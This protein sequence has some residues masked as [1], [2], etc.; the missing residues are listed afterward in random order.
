MMG[1]PRATMLQ[2]SLGFLHGFLKGGALATAHEAG[3]RE[4]RPTEGEL[5][6][7][8]RDHPLIM[9]SFEAGQL[10]RLLLGPQLG[11]AMHY[12]FARLSALGNQAK[13]D[14][15]FIRLSDGQGLRKGDPVYA[16]RE[17]L[18]RNRISRAKRTRSD[19][20]FMTIRAWNAYVRGEKLVY[21]KGATRSKGK[22]T[23][24][25]ALPLIA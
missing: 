2:G 23:A 10:T 14:S 4:P 8:L 5:V 13:A 17:L 25:R 19:I 1:A 11:V 16:L 21:V 7:I 24:S 15:F 12:Y 3:G 6:D 18:Q 20:I 9:D 22:R